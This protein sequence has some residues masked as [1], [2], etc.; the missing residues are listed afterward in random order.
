MNAYIADSFN[1]TDIAG[2][3][4][5]RGRVQSQSPEAA[6]EV[7]RQFEALFIQMM[8]KSMR[9][10]APAE[11]LLSSDQ[12]R[13]FE[14]MFDQ[15][16]ALDMARG[17]GIG[18]REQVARQLAGPEA[19]RDDDRELQMP[20]HR[21]PALRA[22]IEAAM[23]APAASMGRHDTPEADGMKPGQ[24]TSKAGPA[25]G[26]GSWSPRSPQ[27]FIRDVWPH[28]QQAA[29]E[30]GVAPEVLVAQSALETGWG[31]HVIQHGDGRSSY[32]LFGIKADGRWQGDRVTVQT[33]EYVQDIPEMQRAQFR[34]YGSVAESFEDYVDFLR[35]NPR[36]RHALE[37]AGDP[38]QYVRGLQDAGY[39]T[40]PDYADKILN[41]MRR[42]TLSDTLAG[43]KS[44]GERPLS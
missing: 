2:L 41:I 19:R 9:A 37:A 12:T 17:E 38:E 7:A 18:L 25:G 22:A 32:N 28:A 20:T 27:E 44:G 40:D 36:Y 16:V 5:L 15:Q 8:I 11:G 21:V 1:Y 43:F 26:D 14:G 10:A 30:L 42:G 35:S 29:A 24:G 34:S 31:Q 6:D 4:E 23:A 33:L 3:S 39:A 13:M